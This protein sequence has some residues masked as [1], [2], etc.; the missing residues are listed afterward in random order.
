MGIIPIY[1]DAIQTEECPKHIF[2]GGGQSVQEFL[3]KLLE[4]YFDD[5]TVFSLLKNHIECLM[6]MLDKCK[7]CQ[8]A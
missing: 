2:H 7:H 8:I 5:W 4:S 6:L 3:H 1:S